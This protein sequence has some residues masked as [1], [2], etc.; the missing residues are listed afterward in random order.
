M[1][2][3]TGGAV[4]NQQG[5]DIRAEMEGGEIWAFQCKHYKQWSLADTR[6]AI[7]KCTFDA[8]RKFLLV[9]REVSEDCYTEVAKHPVWYIVGCARHLPR[10]S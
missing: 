10:I 5:I 2:G 8:T 3:L 6:A 7:A 1:R 4:D 9:T